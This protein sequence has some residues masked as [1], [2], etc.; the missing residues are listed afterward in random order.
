MTKTDPGAVLSSLVTESVVVGGSGASGRRDGGSSPMQFD[1]V[2]L[3]RVHLNTDMVE[4]FFGCYKGVLLDYST[5][6]ADLASGAVIAVQVKGRHNEDG[7]EVVMAVRERCGPVEPEVAKVLR[8]TSLR[9]MFGVSKLLNAVHCTDLSDDGGLET[10]F[11]F[12][13]LGGL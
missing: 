5:F 3:N 11:F 10:S 13:V 2:G 8:P 4:E 7:R 6:V 1:I 12:D 9:A